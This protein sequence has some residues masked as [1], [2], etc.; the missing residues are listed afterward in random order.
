MVCS[1]SMRRRASCIWIVLWT[2]S[3][4]RSTPS[5]LASPTVG[6]LAV[7]P[8]SPLL[9]F[10]SWTSTTTLQCLSGVSTL[11]PSQKTF[12]WAPRCCGCMQ[13]AETQ[14]QVPRLHTPLSTETIEERS[15]STPIQVNTAALMNLNLRSLQHWLS[16]KFRVN[17]KVLMHT[18][19]ALYGLAPDYLSHFITIYTKNNNRHFS[20]HVLSVV[21]QTRFHLP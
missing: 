6:A 5:A 4:S 2:V 19:I 14:K 12:R 3:F 9:V 8:P 13:P 10:P 17:F 7:S 18:Y 15:A 16:V 11:P 20:Q 1:P 21:H